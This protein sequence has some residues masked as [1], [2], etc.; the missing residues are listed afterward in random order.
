[1]IETAAPV[2]AAA[3]NVPCRGLIMQQFRSPQEMLIGVMDGHGTFGH[4][5]STYIVQHLPAVLMQKLV[6]AAAALHK[7]SSDSSTSQD[8]SGSSRHAGD[9]HRGNKQQ[10]QSQQMQYVVV[11]DHSSSINSS[12]LVTDLHEQQQQQQQVQ[13][14]GAQNRRGRLVSRHKVVHQP[15]HQQSNSNNSSSSGESLPPYQTVPSNLVNHVPLSKGLL[16]AVFAETDH[17]LTCSGVNVLDSGSTA[18]VT[19]IG[20]DTL[21]TAW[22]GDSRAVLGRRLVDADKGLK[23][24]KQHQQQWQ[25]W[26]G[27][28]GSSSSSSQK[29]QVIQLSD[30][31][32]PERPDEQVGDSSSSSSGFAAQPHTIGMLSQLFGDGGLCQ[33]VW[34][35]MLGVC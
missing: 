32:K 6:A 8:N 19:H 24:P 11:P 20:H 25:Q 23:A 16:Q 7:C 5:V 28:S 13:K 10:L 33:H 1:M 26:G 15:E 14:G 29:W 17:M 30:D 35:A 21:T 2:A 31:H 27:G 12:C 22:V 9:K 3:T 18:L 4:L 34:T